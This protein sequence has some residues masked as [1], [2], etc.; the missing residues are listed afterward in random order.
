MPIF[1][2]LISII[3]AAILFVNDDLWVGLF[4]EKITLDWPPKISIFF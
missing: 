3:S 1:E 4:E 2:P